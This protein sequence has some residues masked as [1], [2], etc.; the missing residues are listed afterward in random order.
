MSGESSGRKIIQSIRHAGLPAL[1]TVPRSISGLMLWRFSLAV[2]GVLL[3]GTAAFAQAGDPAAIQQKLLAQFKLTKITADRSDI[4]T[5][6]TGDIVQIH[7]PGLV[8][9]AV[10]SPVAPLNTYKDGKI[11]QGWG[12]FGRDLVG[13]MLTPGSGT[14]A[15]Y[16]H[17]QMP[18]EEKCWVVGIT[19]RNDGAVF[20]LYSDPFDNIRYYADLTIPFPNKK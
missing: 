2:A 19:V 20:R 18:A 12:G 14:T 3:A 11:G 15:N 8:M 17:R 5:D 13:S 16:P 7:K 6:G 1:T 9:Y 10:S 4:A